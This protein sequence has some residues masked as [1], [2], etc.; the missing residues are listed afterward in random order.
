MHP[1]RTGLAG[2]LRRSRGRHKLNGKY[3]NLE[4]AVSAIHA[5][6]GA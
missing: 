1:T 3:R 6:V 2:G 4:T 5:G